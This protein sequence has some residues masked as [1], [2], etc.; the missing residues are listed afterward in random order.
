MEKVTKVYVFSGSNSTFPGGVFLDFDSANNWIKK[1]HLSGTLNVYP[2]NVG[3]YDWAI[4]RG[5][6]E[7]KK[8]DHSNPAFIEKFTSASLEHYHFE[9]GNET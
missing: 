5:Y 9:N 1:H 4:Q 6:F 8:E 3:L 2:V 7:I